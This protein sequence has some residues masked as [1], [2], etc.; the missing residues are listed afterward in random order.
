MR[1]HR[2]QSWV[3]ACVCLLGGLFGSGCVMGRRT[4]DLQMTPLAVSPTLAGTSRDIVLGPVTDERRFQNKPADP[5]IPSVDGDV[6]KTPPGEL[7]RMIGRQRNMYGGAMGD[8]ALP[9]GQTVEAKMFDLIKWVLES[10]GHQV[11]TQSETAPADCI[12]VKINQFWAWFTPGFA[13]VTFE[14]RIQCELI[15][16][17]DKL[18]TSILVSGYG[19]NKGQVASNENW[20]LAYSRAFDHFRGNLAIELEE[21]GL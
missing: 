6:M 15:I 16:T 11:S 3:T 10:R 17:R 14:A 2:L 5:S 9:A 7:K 19:E 20:Q 4:V 12:E 13:Y 18:T 21:E 1:F 8:V